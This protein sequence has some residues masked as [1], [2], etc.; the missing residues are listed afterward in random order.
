MVFSSVGLRPMLRGG[1]KRNR[2][3]PPPSDVSFDGVG[4]GLERSHAGGRSDNQDSA[5]LGN[6]DLPRSGLSGI[7]P[8]A[9]QER[10]GFGLVIVAFQRLFHGRVPGTFGVV[11]VVL[12]RSGYE[13]GIAVAGFQGAN[14]GTWVIFFLGEALAF[15][16]LWDRRY[17]PGW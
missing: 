17:P 16:F 9:L 12:A 7:R 14:Q 5:V 6:F 11:D 3:W 1:S 13:A 4:L 2:A 10:Q 8:R 15:F